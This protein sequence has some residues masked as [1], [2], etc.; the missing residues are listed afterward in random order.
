V[1]LTDGSDMPDD[2]AIA[3]SDVLMRTTF[4]YPASPG[5]PIVSAGPLDIMLPPG[6]YA[7]VF[8]TGAFGGTATGTIPSGGGAGCI[9][10]PGSSYPFTIRQSD[11]MFILQGAQ[12][13]FFVEVAP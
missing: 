12:P 4:A 3:G 1:H 10:S 2:P 5:V 7:V 9:S 11:G 13:H 8:G 6:W